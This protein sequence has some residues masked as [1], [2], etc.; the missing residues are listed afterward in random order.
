MF[1]QKKKKR[2]GKTSTNTYFYVCITCIQKEGTAEQW[3]ES[4]ATFQTPKMTSAISKAPGPRVSHLTPDKGPSLVFQEIKLCMS[5][6]SSE[7]LGPAPAREE[8]AMFGFILRTAYG[9][10]TARG[11]ERGPTFWFFPIDRNGTFLPTPMSDVVGSASPITG[12]QQSGSQTP[13]HFPPVVPA[14]SGSCKKVQRVWRGWEVDLYPWQT[15]WHTAP[16]GQGL[17]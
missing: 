6:G 16:V 1:S 9:A 15:Q 11:K 5:V 17:G 10:P 2:K 14:W 12:R 7:Q 8:C 4:G 13:P 3:L